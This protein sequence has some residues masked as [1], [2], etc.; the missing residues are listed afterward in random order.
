[1]A[2]SLPYLLGVETH[3]I[4]ITHVIQLAVAAVFLLSEVGRHAAAG[5]VSIED[6]EDSFPMES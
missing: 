6:L 1:M 3:I 5:L 2:Q 4:G